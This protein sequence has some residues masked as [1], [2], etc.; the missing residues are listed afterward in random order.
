MT[1][2]DRLL[3]SEKDIKNRQ[4]KDPDRSRDEAIDKVIAEIQAEESKE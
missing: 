1:F 3:K 4:H 2:Y